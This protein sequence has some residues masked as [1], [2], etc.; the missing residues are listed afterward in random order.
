MTRARLRTPIL[1]ATLAMLWGSAFFWIKLSLAG[2][3]PVQLTFARLAL[4]AG[5]LGVIVAARRLALP[6]GARIWGHL[7][8]SALIS[9]AVPY[10]LFALAEQTVPSN[11]AGTI[12]ATTPL[13]TAVA[14]YTAGTDR[15]RS[16]RRI[17][18]LVL[19]FGGA[20]VLLSPWDITDNGSVLGALACL[21]AAISY[22]LSYIYQARHITNRGYSPL[23]LASGQ[24]C[25]ATA[26]LAFTLP[27]VGGNTPRLGGMVL[28]AIL[29]LGILGT[30]GAYVVN[31]ALIT[32]EGP[33]SASMVTYLVPV[34]SVA[35][36]AAFLGES[37]GSNLV[38]GAAL[39]LL[40]VAL[41]QQHT[42]A[43]AAAD[44]SRRM[45]GGI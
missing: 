28:L 16:R 35:F 24:L 20:L 26:L 41:V 23:V 21:G 25:A 22:G 36:G 42:S 18:G 39:I 7:A 17:V 8:V 44:Q 12:N 15:L 27:M 5:V 9:N 31:Y 32:T 29:I 38:V 6:R 10:T 1:I 45:S 30:G 3:S 11:L 43:T 13:W 4:G 33:T 19:G 37:V 2:L 40:G 14:A 34:V